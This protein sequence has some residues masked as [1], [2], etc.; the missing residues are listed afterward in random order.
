[1][2][3]NCIRM[4]LLSNENKSV[5][6]PYIDSINSNTKILRY[7]KNNESINTSKTCG[8]YYNIFFNNSKILFAICVNKYSKLVTEICSDVVSK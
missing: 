2:A 3:E 6:Y 5:D 7:N 4:P 1:M 8:D